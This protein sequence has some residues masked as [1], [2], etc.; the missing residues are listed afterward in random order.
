MDSP[1]TSKTS[2]GNLLP[3][4]STLQSGSAAGKREKVIVHAAYPL[5]RKHTLVTMARAKQL[6]DDGNEV[7][8]TYCNS[9]AG[10]CAV[11]YT[12]NPV[13]CLIC[14]NRTRQ[15]AEALGLRTIPL[16]TDASVDTDCPALPMSEKKDILEGVQSGV[17]STFRMMPGDSRN[18]PIIEPIKRRYFATA[19]RLLKSMK[20]VVAGEQPTRVEVFN[21]RHGCSR[22]AI[23]AAQSASLPFNTLE[24]T[25]RQKPIVHIGCRVHDRKNIQKRILTHAADM[26]TAEAFFSRRRTPRSNK[27]AKKHAIAFIP[28]AS[29]SFR[30]RI[31]IFLSSQ[32]EFASLGKEWISPFLDYAPI[33]HRAA[34][35]NPDDLFVIRFHPNQADIVSDIITPFREI[36]KLP[37]VVVYYPTDTANTY[38]LMDWSDVVVTFGST[39]TIEACW[40]GKPVILLGPSYFDEL[41]VSYNPADVDGFLQLLRQPLFP[42]DRANAARFAHYAEFDFDPLHYV[43]FDGRTI[44][45]AGFYIHKPWLS[46]IARTTDNVICHVIKSVTDL[47]GGKKRRAA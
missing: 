6:Q 10:T 35:E 36:E 45:P 7:V 39:V 21:G 32:D 28:P 1:H 20:R 43:N 11:N 17:I 29:D 41:D 5:W 47:T 38:T 46:Q 18:N 15:T 2:E 23:I 4:G 42:K 30:R 19:T 13:A 34:L 8:V 24:V 37:N 22:F 9:T 26:E 31:G 33:V 16:A 40:S 44:V 12:G 14:R 3:H 25:A 27:Y